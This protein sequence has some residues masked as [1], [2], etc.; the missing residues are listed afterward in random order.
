[1]LLAGGLHASAQDFIVR[2]LTVLGANGEELRIT[3]P[4]G[5]RIDFNL[6]GMTTLAS[7][8]TM[9]NPTQVVLTA[10]LDGGGKVVIGVDQA[11]VAMHAKEEPTDFYSETEHNTEATRKIPI[12]ISNVRTP[13]QELETTGQVTIAVKNIHAMVDADL[14]VINARQSYELCLRLPGPQKG[15]VVTCSPMTDLP[16]LLGIAYGSC[17]EDGIIKIKVVNPG[18][19]AVDLPTTTFSI[20]ILNPGVSR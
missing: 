13:N 3:A 4:V 8:G 14:P 12:S 15:A 1:M 17:Q 5:E 7:L 6:A 20:S 2:G 19:D 9:G 18:P 11:M 10:Y 16:G